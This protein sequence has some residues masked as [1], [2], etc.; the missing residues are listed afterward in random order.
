MQPGKCLL[1]SHG[2]SPVSQILEEEGRYNAGHQPWH[3]RWDPEAPRVRL[4]LGSPGEASS[5]DLPHS[6]PQPMS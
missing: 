1:R 2:V 3:P 5:A 4:W 6:A